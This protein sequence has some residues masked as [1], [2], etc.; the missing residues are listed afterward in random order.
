MGSNY[1]KRNALSLETYLPSG[2][3]LVHGKVLV[4]LVSVSQVL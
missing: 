1:R 3:S 2:D 4:I